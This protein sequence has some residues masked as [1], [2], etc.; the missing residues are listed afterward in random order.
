[1]RQTT[2]ITLLVAAVM[3]VAVFYLKN[4]V[5]EL[6]AELG[7][8]NRAIVVDREAIHVLR[9]E[10]SHLNDVGRIGV[11]AENYLGMS[12]VR[13]HQIRRLDDLSG[14]T[15]LI[16]AGLIDDGNERR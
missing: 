14:L 11:L 8:L 15:D 4:E 2:V 7:G 5:S 9:A 6:K 12:P 13:P 1:M 3:S 10:W 16:P